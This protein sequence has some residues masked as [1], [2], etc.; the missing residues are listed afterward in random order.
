MALAGQGCFV[1]WYDLKPGRE[2]EHDHWH[3]HEHMI[4]RV[5]IPGFR[6]G[7][8]YRSLGGAPRVCVV[9][10]TDTLE[11]LVSPAYMERLNT[12][13][14][15]TTRSMSLFSGM[16]R[17]LCRVAATHGAGIGGTLLTIQ[18]SP[19]Q[20]EA[21]RLRGWLAGETLATLASRAGI[22][23]AHL[24]V[25]DSAASQ[26]KSEEKALRGEADKIADWVL[27]IEGYDRAAVE[28]ALAEL[29]GPDGLVA[30]GAADAMAPGLYALDFTLG[31]DE[32]KRIWKLP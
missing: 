28:H 30:H 7:A 18:L 15:W 22:S 16:N 11:T 1:C 25:G 12:P 17:T 21:D 10:Q 9:Y 19:R 3:T 6:R 2:A 8:R 20:G 29:R 14:P 4:E 5:A 27:L 13:T 26:T 31:E 23:G 32:A 24:L